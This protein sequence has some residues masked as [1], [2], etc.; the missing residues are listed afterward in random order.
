MLLFGFAK[1]AK[2]ELTQVLAGFER[3]YGRPPPAIS[4]PMIRDGD[5]E[6]G[7]RRRESD[8]ERLMRSLSEDVSMNPQS[9]NQRHGYELPVPHHEFTLPAMTFPPPRDFSPFS[10]AAQPSFLTEL[11]S[12]PSPSVGWNSALPDGGPILHSATPREF[13]TTIGIN[14]GY[15]APQRLQE[16]VFWDTLPEY[17]SWFPQ[18]GCPESMYIDNLQEL[19]STPVPWNQ[20]GDQATMT[21]VERGSHSSG[22]SSAMGSPT[23]RSSPSPAHLNSAASTLPGT[24]NSSMSSESFSDAA[25]E[26]DHFHHGVSSW[27]L[28]QQAQPAAAP[29]GSSSA[30]RKTPDRALDESCDEIQS[31]DCKKPS[32]KTRRKGPKR[33]REPRY[34]IQ[35]RSD[36]EIME[37]GYKWRKYGQKAVKNSPHPRSYYRC[38][39]PK[40]PVRKRVERSADDTSLV[41]TTYE[42][43]HTHVS[44]STGS[45]AASDAPLL[46]ASGDH[47]PGGAPY[48]P[49]SGSSSTSFPFQ[50]P[51]MAP[52]ASRTCIKYEIKD[53][54][55]MSASSAGPLRPTPSICK[56]EPS[57]L[58]GGGDIRAPL[59]T[60]L[61]RAQQLL[62]GGPKCNDHLIRD[63]QDAMCWGISSGI[64]SHHAGR[65]Q[66]IHS[67]LPTTAP[68]S[69]SS[70]GLLEDIVRHRRH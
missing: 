39:N 5:D 12:M 43:T 53:S 41:I 18:E 60:A 68:A 47:P 40:C 25:A 9:Q 14:H 44:P 67:L 55:T 54:S 59:S 61:L 42:G 64:P 15:S 62:G 8:L 58:A 17:P 28:L 7:G 46:P 6:G 52:M 23:S 66:E 29:S 27:P 13:P 48:Q 30:K 10:Q 37:D 4:S 51:A 24:P 70:E 50:T 19:M 16:A 69:S 22:R 20:A 56:V 35:T 63:L 26:E 34:A 33:L 45:R 49:P 57:F 65:T 3:G 11:L 38:T 1:Y 2:L 31:L 36:V 32:H 21:L